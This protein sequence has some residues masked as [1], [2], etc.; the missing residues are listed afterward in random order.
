MSLL[1]TLF[2][3]GV[4]VATA[5]PSRPAKSLYPAEEAFVS[6]AVEQRRREFAIGRDCARMA[7]RTLGIAAQAI[8]AGIDRAPIWPDGMVGSI[9]H[10]AGLCGAV[11][12]R[13]ANGFRSL[14]LDI[15]PA[16]PLDDDLMDAI[17][18]GQEIDWLE[19]L[20]ACQSGLMARAIF[21]AKETVYKTQYPLSGQL[22]DF[23][24]VSIRLD[25]A[26]ASFAATFH[27]NASPFRVDEQLQGRFAIDAG[28]I[29]T[30][31]ALKGVQAKTARQEFTAWA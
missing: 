24:A 31:M 15:E 6:H 23:H 25:M 22:I 12:A 10:C 28:F 3:P 18:T 1:A 11:V 16:S 20:P 14:G 30:A 17:C 4:G 9:S 29:V 8:P 13:R 26:A 19:A 27:V 5:D 2:E 21:S 7:M